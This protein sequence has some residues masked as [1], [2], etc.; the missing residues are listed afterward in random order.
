MFDWRGTLVH[1]PPDDWWMTQA[2]ERVGRSASLSTVFAL[3]EQLRSAAQEPEIVAAERSADCSP[4]LHRAASTRRFRAAGFDDELATALYDLDLEPGSHPFYPDVPAVLR[5]LHER[6]C[7][8]ALV[9]DIHFDLRPE[10]EA[11][12]VAEYVDA[13]ILSFEH[14]VQKPN[15]EIFEIALRMLGAAP[16]ETLMVGDRASHD[17]GAVAV[18]ITTL[19]FPALDSATSSRGLADVL[20]LV[21]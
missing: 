11:A 4:A 5:A 15:P 20:A 7:R 1:D 19:L 8:V 16:E 13:F 10:F 17:G 2:L 14:G 6:G 18:G 3:C 9:S 21:H 12:G